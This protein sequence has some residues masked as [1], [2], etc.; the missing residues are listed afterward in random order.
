MKHNSLII[1]QAINR[2]YTHDVRECVHRSWLSMGSDP[3]WHHESVWTFN[4]GTEVNVRGHGRGAALPAEP[5]FEVLFVDYQRNEDDPTIVR[6]PVIG[7]EVAPS[8]FAGTELEPVVQH[9]TSTAEP[10]QFRGVVQPD[11]RVLCRRRWLNTATKTF[12]S[13][14]PAPPVRSPTRK[15][16]NSFNSPTGETHSPMREPVVAPRRDHVAR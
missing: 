5:G 3:R 7:W 10:S 11:G 15:T 12:M 1:E 6:Q 8:D 16:Q 9:V 13:W 2:A 4:D 14:T